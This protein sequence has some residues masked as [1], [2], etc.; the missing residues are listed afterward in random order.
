MHHRRAGRA[1]TYVLVGGRLPAAWCRVE[2]RRV[3]VRADGHAVLQVGRIRLRD[4]VERPR[5]VLMLVFVRSPGG[6]VGG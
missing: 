1:G 3:G 5:G 6:V 2:R 4:D